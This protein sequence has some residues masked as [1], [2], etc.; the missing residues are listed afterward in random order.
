MADPPF[1]DHPNSNA[2]SNFQTRFRSPGEPFNVPANRQ[3]Q[4]SV[5]RQCV[6]LIPRWH[7]AT[8]LLK[9]YNFRKPI[10]SAGQKPKTVS[11]P[12]LANRFR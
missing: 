12:Q 10:D 1:P 2:S 6:G 8:D 3:I 11:V 9:N 4:T 7:A 5:P